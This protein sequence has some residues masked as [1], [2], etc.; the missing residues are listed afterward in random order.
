MI[1]LPLDASAEEIAATVVAQLDRVA[2]MAAAL[3]CLP[4]DLE[5]R[6][7]FFQSHRYVEDLVVTIVRISPYG[8]VID[9]RAP[10]PSEGNGAV[11]LRLKAAR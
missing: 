5:P 11:G 4:A 3:G 2:R 1:D 8:L 9:R 10:S 7:V 6:G